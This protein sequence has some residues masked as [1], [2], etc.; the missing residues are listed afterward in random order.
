MPKITYDM[1]NDVFLYSKLPELKEVILSESEYLGCDLPHSLYGNVLNPVVASLIKKDEYKN[2][3]LLKKI[4]DLY[5]QMAKYGDESVKNLLQVTLLE[6]LWDDYT[7]YTR[8]LEMMGNYT[9]EI[10][11]EILDYLYLPTEK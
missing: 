10:N 4:F 11:K 2:N 3:K 5:E 9:L 8:S 6:Y 1:L 7:I